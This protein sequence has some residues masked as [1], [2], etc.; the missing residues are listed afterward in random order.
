MTSFEKYQVPFGIVPGYHDFEGDINAH[1]MLEF[2]SKNRYSASLPNH[3]DYYGSEMHHQFTFEL[4]IKN[5]VH[6]DIVDARLWFFGTG[7]ADCMGSGGMNCINR[8]QIEWFKDKSDSYPLTDARRG[9]GIAFMHHALQEHMTLANHYPI[10]GQKRDVSRCQ[11]LNTGLF[12][13]IKQKGT[14]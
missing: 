8:D 6:K 12:S 2:V 11:G 1:Q 10:H 3:Y 14:I 9:N 4:P 5:A 7:R 13:E